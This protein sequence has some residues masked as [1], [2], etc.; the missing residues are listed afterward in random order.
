MRVRHVLATTFVRYCIIGLISVCCDL[1]IFLFL[2]E[3]GFYY[4]HA[5][6]IGY[7]SG[8]VLSFTLNRKYNFK[9]HDNALRRLLLFFF[10]SGVGLSFS[11][12]YLYT[13]VDLMSQPSIWSKI[14]SLVFVLLIQFGLNKFITF[15]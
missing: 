5:N 3:A 14:S 13:L 8:T 7:M 2:N 9:V 12:L 15:R 4:Q 6:I 10:A 1:A 11:T